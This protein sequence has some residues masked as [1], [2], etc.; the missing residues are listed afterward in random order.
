MIPD[1]WNPKLR[2]PICFN[3]AGAR[4]QI[5]LTIKRTDM[6]LAGRSKEQ[7]FDTLDS[8]TKQKDWAPPEPGAMCYMLSKQGY[9]SDVGGHWRPHL[10]FFVPETDPEKWGA[11]MS[12]SPVIGFKDER[13]HLTVFIVPVE[14]W[15]DG[16]VASADAH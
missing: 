11:G 4:S 14:R 3:A 8:A 9:L 16:T 2:G 1:F 6:V 10:M 15:S 5:P 7:V 12:G 13:E